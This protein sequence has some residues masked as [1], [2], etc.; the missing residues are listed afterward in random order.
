MLVMALKHLLKRLAWN[1]GARA[2]YSP[3]GSYVWKLLQRALLAGVLGLALPQAYAQ[4]VYLV[5]TIGSRAILVID[6]APPKTLAVGQSH[7]GVEVLFVGSDQAE[8]AVNG[9]HTVLHLGQMPMQAKVD[10]PR[11]VLHANAQGHF[12]TDGLLNGRPVT[13]LIDTGASLVS[14]S[15]DL[16]KNLGINYEQAQRV[17]KVNT[18]NGEIEG[19]L[20]ELDSVRIGNLSQHNVSALVMPQ[21]LPYVL[22]GNS[23]LSGLHLTRQAQT[24]T[25]Q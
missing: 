17:V 22:L 4:S 12:L 16:A 23:F 15:A 20:I 1:V 13:F 18:A 6:Q 19:W 8:V 24:M 25:I 2:S 10:R 3:A 14:M 5:G 9:E 11:L 21:S 7:K